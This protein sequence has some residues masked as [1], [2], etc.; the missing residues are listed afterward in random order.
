MFSFS[1]NQPGDLLKSPCC[2]QNP[3][4]KQ[5]TRLVLYLSKMALKLKQRNLGCCCYMLPNFNCIK[6]KNHIRIHTLEPCQ[7]QDI[8]HYRSWSTGKLRMAC[9]LLITWSYNFERINYARLNN[10]VSHDLLKLNG[11]QSCSFATLSQS[12][13]SLVSENSL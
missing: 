2:P 13:L 10:I 8:G 1:S 6:I 3:L 4:Q 7:L 9:F 11:M 5:L 12:C